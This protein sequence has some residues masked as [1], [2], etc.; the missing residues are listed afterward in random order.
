MSRRPSL[1]GLGIGLA[2]AGVGAAVGLAAER[3]AVGRPVVRRLPTS[4]DGIPLGSL[5]DVPVMVTTD[6][7]TQLYAEIDEPDPGSEG[8][9][10]T[11]SA[12]GTAPLTVVFCHGYALNLDSWHYQRLALQGRVR[13]VYWDQRGHGRSERG[14]KLSANIPQLGS[15]L[16]AVI[17]ATAPSGPLVLIGHSMGG[18]TIMAFTRQ[19][20]E[21]ITSRLVG[22]GLIATSSGGLAN[23]DLGLDRFGFLLR[24]LAPRAISVLNIQPGLVERSR[25]IGSDLE[26]VIVKRWSFSSDVDEVLVDFTARM[27]ASTRLDVVGDFMSQFNRHDEAAALRHL[28][29]AEALVLTGDDDLMIPPEHSAAIADALPRCEYAVIKDAGHLV[30][31]E[32]PD[33]VTP[34][35]VHLIHRAGQAV[36]EAATIT[37]REVQ[38]RRRPRRRR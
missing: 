23:A 13:C 25:R 24:R 37:A 18:M 33:V 4:D 28:A 10:L 38:P 1:I 21:T 12:P 2:A 27:I 19:F 3:L 6:D 16:A 7:G 32:H 11:D 30:M 26:E 36:G 15:D 5:R 29:G 9:A 14:D 22:V 17:R 34:H 20:P 35:V 8:V 31:L